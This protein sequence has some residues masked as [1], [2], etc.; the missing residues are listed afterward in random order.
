MVPKMVGG[1]VWFW[2]WLSDL[3]N[4]SFGIGDV[5]LTNKILS[6]KFRLV[7]GIKL[8]NQENGKLKN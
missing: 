2:E 6:W 8:T 4:F 3:L 7:R 1:M 5:E